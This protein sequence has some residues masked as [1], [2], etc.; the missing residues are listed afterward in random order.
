MAV[1][2]GA[3]TAL[4]TQTAINNTT[5][6][7]LHGSGLGITLATGLSCHVQ[8]EVDNEAGSVTDDLLVAIYTTLD[9]SSTHRQSG[10]MWPSC[11]S[12]T[13]LLA[14]PL[15]ESPSLSLV[16]TTSVLECCRV[17]LQTLTVLVATTGFAPHKGVTHAPN[18][19]WPMVG[20]SWRC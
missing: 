4:T 16:F 10:M 13:L 2:W 17:E 20:Q 12:L 9:D 3:K 14:L 7:F 6:E 5:E 19:A 1:T 18:Q 15:S 11:P 8:L